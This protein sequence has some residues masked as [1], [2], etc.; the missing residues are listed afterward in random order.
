MK[1]ILPTI[2]TR[3]DLQPYIALALGLQTA[4]HLPIIAT[5]PM[6]R[7]LVESYGLEF[8][9]IGPDIDLG[10]E[11]AVIRGHSRNWMAGFLRVMKF[12]FSML[13]KS[14]PHLLEICR[15][16]DLIVISHS[17]AG[18]IEADSLAACRREDEYK[19]VN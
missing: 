18:S 15:N 4:G 13:E 14:H 16:A 8:A 6:M 5:H 9:P 17:A 19:V 7:G 3:G 1:I 2:G 10:Y 12:S 11:A